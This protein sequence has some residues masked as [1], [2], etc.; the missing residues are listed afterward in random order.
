MTRRKSIR[1]MEK[2]NCADLKISPKKGDIEKAI[3]GLHDSE[4]LI[5]TRL[6]LTRFINYLKFNPN[7]LITLNEIKE[8]TNITKINFMI[9]VHLL[10]ELNLVVT[11]SPILLQSK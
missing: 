11:K 2:T 1:L 5:K 10:T 9:A 4:A 3:Y 7:K 6:Q 8:H